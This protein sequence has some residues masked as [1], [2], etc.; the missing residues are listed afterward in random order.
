MNMNDTGAALEAPENIEKSGSALEILPPCGDLESD[1]EE[2]ALALAERNQKASVIGR[3]SPFS[4]EAPELDA[5]TPFARPTA[6]NPQ[7][8]RYRIS[9]QRP[10]RGMPSAHAQR[11]ASHGH[12]RRRCRY[13]QSI[14]RHGDQSGHRRREGRSRRRQAA[15]CG[16]GERV[17]SASR[18]RACTHHRRP[19]KRKR[20][21]NVISSFKIL[22]PGDVWNPRMGAPPGNRNRLKNG[23]YTKKAKALRARVFDF[24]KRVKVMLAAVDEETKFP[25]PHECGG[26]GRVRG[27]LNQA[28]IAQQ[29]IDKQIGGESVPLTQPSPPEGGEGYKKITNNPSSARPPKSIRESRRASIR[30]S[31]LF[32]GAHD[33][34]VTIANPNR[35]MPKNDGWK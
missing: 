17:S 35:K 33:S 32:S 20:V 25:R 7:R 3:T 23:R 15:R 30:P 34:V 26:E 22:W 21:A 16:H 13:A 24:K 5:V 11:R 27:C 31:L 1:T 29:K 14:P 4:E 9:A 12:A 10:H 2:R 8:Q 28:A 6:R 18:H 19:P